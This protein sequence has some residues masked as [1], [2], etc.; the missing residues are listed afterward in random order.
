V[1][2]RRKL[3]W[4]ISIILTLIFLWIL[5]VIASEFTG[6]NG[7]NIV[8]GVVILVVVVPFWVWSY[9]RGRFPIV[10]IGSRRNGQ[11]QRT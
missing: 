3:S 8:E 2:Y 1:K 11:T 4:A 5:D 7:Q 6:L 9:R 10:S